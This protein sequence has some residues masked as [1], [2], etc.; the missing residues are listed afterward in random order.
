MNRHIR[1]K[2]SDI[3]KINEQFARSTRID[4]DLIEQSGFIYS[5]S[6][7]T[8]LGTLIK[9]QSSSKQSAYTWTGPYGSGKSTLALSLNSVLMGDAKARKQ[10]AKIY[11]QETAENLWKAFPP[12]KNGWEIISLVGGKGNLEDLVK[13]ALIA[14]GILKSKDIPENSKGLELQELII[15]AIETRLN[16]Q[17]T[18]GGLILFVDEMGK[19]LE[20]ASE[21]DG[22]VYFYQLLAEARDTKYWPF[23]NNWDPSSIFPR[24]CKFTYKTGTR[25]MG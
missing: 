12:G 8:F 4:S 24:V 1:E 13:R 9:H 17:E 25:R 14:E 2:L 11:N 6:I 21:G 19:L 22:D 7:D 23:C 16:D 15:S 20:A 18:Y 3:V 5:E 10:A